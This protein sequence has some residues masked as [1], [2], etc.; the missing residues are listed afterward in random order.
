MAFQEPAELFVLNWLDGV[1]ARSAFHR[2]LLSGCSMDRPC[3]L[4]EL[5]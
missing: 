3:S 4:L 5:H 1:D 2:D